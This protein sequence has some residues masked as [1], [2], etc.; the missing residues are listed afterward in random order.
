M[1]AGWETYAQVFGIY[2]SMMVFFI[3]IGYKILKRRRSR[4]SLTCSM[5]YFL[6]AGAFLI[7]IVYRVIGLHEVNIILNTMTF[8]L[9]CLGLLFLLLFNQILLKSEK[10]F[11]AKKQAAYI[12]GYLV[13]LSLY[14][15]FMANGQVGFQYEDISTTEIYTL[16]DD[17]QLQEDLGVP[18][19]KW[20][21]AIY[22]LIIT[23]IVYGWTMYT[24]IKLRKKMGNTQFAKKYT[25]NL[26]GEMLFDVVPV[27]TIL[28]NTINSELGR[29]ILPL[30]S[31]MVIP[32]AIL[33]YKGLK[34]EKKKE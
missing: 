12:I 22:G 32:A 15:V 28:V 31:L 8:F 18:V 6:V 23:Q 24:G 2:G 19:W 9:G 26:I 14:F 27:G 1:M 30:V 13:L 7:N 29:T 25:Y 3:I 10:V 20:P 11:T 33:V 17:P 16:A 21:F 5:F 4:L 34:S